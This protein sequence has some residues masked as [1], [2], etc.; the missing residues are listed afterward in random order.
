MLQFGMLLTP[1]V[2]DT[3]CYLI[4]SSE[5]CSLLNHL[6]RL[7]PLSPYQAAKLAAKA[8]KV[9]AAAAKAEARAAAAAAKAAGG[10]GEDK[11][12]NKKAEAEAKK[13][14]GWG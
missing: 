2:L 3:G 14:C 9:A 8:A 12:A 11:K 7:C 10:G 1:P 5:P 13:V 6:F 4:V